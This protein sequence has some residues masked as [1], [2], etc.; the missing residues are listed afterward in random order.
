MAFINVQN[1]LL[2]SYGTWQKF[3]KRKSYMS[4]CKP[5]SFYEQYVATVLYEKSLG[6]NC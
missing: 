5:V 4:V 6:L 1:A 2:W 3:E